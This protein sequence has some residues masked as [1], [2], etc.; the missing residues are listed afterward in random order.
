[1]KPLATPLTWASWTWRMHLMRSPGA[2][3]AV[4]GMALAAPAT[5]I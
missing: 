4:V 3:M 5:P 2:M 1:M